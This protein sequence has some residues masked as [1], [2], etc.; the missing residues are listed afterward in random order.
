MGGQ[1]HAPQA[2]EHRRLLAHITSQGMLSSGC[3]I[4]TESSLGLS[5]QG[6]AASPDMQ[7]PLRTQQQHQHAM[8]ELVGH[9]LHHFN[10]VELLCCLSCCI[11]QSCE[12]AMQHSA[13]SLEAFVR[14]LPRRQAE[15]VGTHD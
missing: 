3:G 13:S 10:S 8:A 1:L 5:G 11:A 6:T 2:E 9:L 7:V 14:L 4:H 15:G 12:M